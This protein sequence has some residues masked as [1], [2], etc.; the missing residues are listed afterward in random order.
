MLQSAR[1]SLL[2]RQSYPQCARVRKLSQEGGGGGDA[3][4]VP[5]A[6]RYRSPWSILKEEFKGVAQGQSI[7]NALPVPRETDVLVIGGGA[8]GS[9]VAFWLKNRNPKAMS[10]TVLE[11]DPSY[12]RAATMLSVG[13]I[14]HQFSLE[15]NIQLSMFT[16]DFLRNIKQHLSVLDESPPDVQYNNQGYLFL[17]TSRSAPLLEKNVQ[18]QRKMGAKIDLMSKEQLG[19]KFPW[20]NTAGVEVG[21]YGLEGEGWFDPWL[22]V[23][24]LKQKNISLGVKYVTGELEAFETQEEREKYSEGGGPDRP[25]KSLVN[26]L[27]RTRDDKLYSTKF[28]MV[29]NCAGPWAG[30]VAMKAMIGSGENIDLATPLPVEPRKRFVYV[31]HCP[32]GPGLDTPFLVDPTG[33]YFRREGFGGYFLCG[34]SPEK[35]KEPSTADLDVDYNFFNDLIW[36]TLSK[37]VPAFECLKLKS[38]WAGYYDYN[39]ADQNLIIGNH[40]YHR[41]FFFAN[42]LTGHGLQHSVAVGRAIMELIVDGEF[43]TI[44]LSRFGFERFLMDELVTED[45]IV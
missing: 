3:D 38:A 34:A 13:G 8:V 12:T 36:P 28:A 30:E 40:P 6:G 11:R 32:D 14:R 23:K 19:A 35:D 44:D 20:L 17:A 18:L 4:R 15:E 45:H 25:H 10:V 7:D 31:V 33:V 29:V 16:T 5:P 39:Y 24:A 2:L 22:L 43:K 42:G 9:S 27:I 26:A 21:S 41:N 1:L 37:R